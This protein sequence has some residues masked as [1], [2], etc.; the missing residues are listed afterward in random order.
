M[1]NKINTSLIHE[2]MPNS[3][4][5]KQGSSKGVSK[6]GSDASIHVQYADLIA[7]AMDNPQAAEQ[8]VQKAKSLLESG[9]LDSVEYIKQ[10]AENIQE[11]GW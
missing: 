8:A 11:F 1:I 7:G 3:S 9:Q 4:N 10:A 5:R 2:I 6:S